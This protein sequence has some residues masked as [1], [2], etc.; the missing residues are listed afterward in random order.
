MIT[1]ISEYDKEYAVSNS[2]TVYEVSSGFYKVVKTWDTNGYKHVKLYKGGVRKTVYVHRLVAEY[3]I[4]KSPSASEVNH[5]NGVKEDNRA[6]NLE[7]CTHEE[8]IRH[9]VDVLGMNRKRIVDIDSG[10][11]F[12][13]LT[14]ASIASGAAIPNISNVLNGKRKS[15]AGRRWRFI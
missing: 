8:N 3:F 13:S 2:G 15:S 10:E 5:K 1:T 4:E 11:I 12:N 9:A 6:E 7:W 14:E